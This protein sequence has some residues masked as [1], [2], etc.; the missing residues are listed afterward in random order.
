[1]TRS[2][3]R[4]IPSNPQPEEAYGCQNDLQDGNQHFGFLPH[5]KVCSETNSL[6]VYGP[7]YPSGSDQG[8][9]QAGALNLGSLRPAPGMFFY[10]QAAPRTFS[11]ST[12]R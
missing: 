4:A 9:K 2:V 8:P 6:S 10:E 7:L 1:M 3:L 12:L 11:A 5:A